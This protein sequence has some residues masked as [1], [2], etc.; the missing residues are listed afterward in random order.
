MRVTHRLGRPQA[1][2]N[3]EWLGASGNLWAGVKLYYGPDKR[4]VFD[5]LGGN[6]RYIAP[7]GARMR[8][9]KVRYPTG[10]VEWKS[11][12]HIIGGQYFVKP[13]DPALRRMEWQVYQF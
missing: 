12:A 2:P 9:V 6:D 3:P 10:E 7:D 1:R 4:Y 8:A 11:R 13:D 5:V